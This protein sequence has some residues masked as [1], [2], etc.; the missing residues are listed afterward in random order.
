MKKIIVYIIGLL[1]LLCGCTS[2]PAD[3]SDV[4]FEPMQNCEL[5]DDII[6]DYRNIVSSRISDYDGSLWNDSESIELSDT[7]N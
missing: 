1:V 6:K 3:N 2:Q 4:N 5:Y 7:L